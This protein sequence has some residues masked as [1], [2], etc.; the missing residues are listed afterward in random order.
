MYLGAENVPSPPYSQTDENG[1]TQEHAQIGEP[2]G[3][4]Q[5]ETLP[6]GLRLLWG[7]GLLPPLFSHP[8][9]SRGQTQP[10]TPAPL[11]AG[12]Q[13][14][15]I[16][17]QT[18]QTC[19]LRLVGPPERRPFLG[20]LLEKGQHLV[21]VGKSFPYGDFRCCPF[22]CPGSLI[23]IPWLLATVPPGFRW[24]QQA[25]SWVKLQCSGQ[26]ESHS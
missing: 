7:L 8:P 17:W 10:V 23:Y 2:R 14:R 21:R 24:A 12:P 26:G 25:D 5:V 1:R 11:Q 18:W 9:V 15:L 6:A 3:K 4:A 22:S 20:A 16:L 19:L 13:G